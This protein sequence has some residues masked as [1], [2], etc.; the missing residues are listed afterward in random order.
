MKALDKYKLGNIELKNRLVMSPMC[1]YSAKD[2]GKANDFHFIHYETRAIGGVGLIIVEATAVMPNGRIS[3]QDLG[4]WSDEQIEGLREITSRIKKHG[5]RAGIQIAHAGRKSEATKTEPFAPSA[6]K[7]SEDYRMPQVLDEN[8]IQQVVQAFVDGAK[9]AVIAGFDYIEIHGAH[10]YLNHEFLS[11]ITNQREDQFGGSLQNR[12]RLLNWIIDQVKASIPEHVAL[13][14]RVSA[15]DYVDGGIDGDE[16]VKI[17]DQVKGKLDIVHTSSGGLA[18]VAMRVYPGYQIQFA[19][20]IKHECQVAT[21]TVGLITSIEM[22][23]EILNN[24]RSDLIAL[25]RLLLRD[26]YFPL[27][28]YHQSGVEDGIPKAYKRGF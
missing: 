3:D 4:I 16:M 19:E 22:I 25:G 9:R 1:M 18:P 20:Q 5:A 15:S 24:N 14:L 13:G 17:I 28:V 26:P 12:C 11:P 7:F 27:K 8:Q 23:E 2:D 10:G 6:L 21:I